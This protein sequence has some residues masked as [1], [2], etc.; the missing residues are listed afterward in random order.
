MYILSDFKAFANTFFP[1]KFL[2]YSRRQ[3]YARSPAAPPCLPHGS[4]RSRFAP[5]ITETKMT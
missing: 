5:T 1:K 3:S 2:P 4:F